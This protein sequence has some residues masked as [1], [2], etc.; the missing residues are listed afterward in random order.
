MWGHFNKFCLKYTKQ[1]GV[2]CSKSSTK[3][4]D[5]L[6]LW[7]FYNSSCFQRAKQGP[8]GRA[9]HYGVARRQELILEH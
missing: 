1:H 5:F 8:L 6:H 9:E 2:W 4:N 3:R 7:L